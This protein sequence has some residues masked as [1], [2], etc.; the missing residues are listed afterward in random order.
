MAFAKLACE[1]SD[2]MT[3]VVGVQAFGGVRLFLDTFVS[4]SDVVGVQS[5]N[6][7]VAIIQARY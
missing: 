3:V 2:P 4:L 7:D 5:G 1:H 6:R